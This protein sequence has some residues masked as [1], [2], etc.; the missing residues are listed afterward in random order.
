MATF[1]KEY[2][3]IF[4]LLACVLKNEQPHEKPSDLSF[5]NIYMIAKKHTIENMLFYA[6]EK[7]HTKPEPELL[8]KWSEMRDKAIIRDFNQ[9]HEFTVMSS[10]F[11]ANKV[12][13]LPLKGIYIKD[14]Y[15][16]RDMR[17]MSD[18]DILID[19]KNAKKIREIMLSSGYQPDMEGDDEHDAYMKKPHTYFEMHRKL[20]SQRGTNFNKLFSDPWKHAK[21]QEPY[22]WKFDLNWSF[23]YTFA[24]LA[25]HYLSSGTGIRSVMD[26]WVYINSYGNE[27]DFDYIYKQLDKSGTTELC[28]DIIKLS[29]IWFDGEPS[30]EKYDKMTE[31]IISCGVYGTKANATEHAY[32]SMSK[33]RYVMYRLFP[34][35]ARMRQ[36]YPKLLTKAPFMLPFTWIHRAFKLLFFKRDSISWEIDLLKNHEQTNNKN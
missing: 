10:K 22:L 2:E 31:Y 4:H 11:E 27:L 13:F 20:F 36:S 26:I 35:F 34:P 21:E 30:S 12:R 14:M 16:Q 32:E 28:K 9:L 5:E 19:S 24:H 3:Y 15:P 25:K 23:I 7:L 17:S 33:F 6:I 29:H 18:I 8:K 1:N